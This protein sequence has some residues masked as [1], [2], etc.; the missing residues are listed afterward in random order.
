[1]KTRIKYDRQFQK[2][3]KVLMIATGSVLILFA[4]V[5][6]ATWDDVSSMA[7][8]VVF[9]GLLAYASVPLFPLSLILY[10]DATIYLIRLEKN[11]FSIPEKKKDYDDDLR[12]VPR[13][14]VVENCYAKD[15][16]I[17]MALA[18]AA[19]AVVLICD[20]A[21]L[22]L[23]LGY[24]ES[25]AVAL[26]VILM[27]LHSYFPIQAV[28]FSKQRDVQKYVDEVDVRDFRKARTGLMGAIGLLL[29]AGMIAALSVGMAHTMT[30]YVYKSRNRQYER[31]MDDFH[32]K[33][34][35]QPEVGLLD[36]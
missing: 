11:H 26:F 36:M 19:Y 31:T 7:D 14:E 18:L 20:V 15:S 28:R 35:A 30:K 34:T 10:L 5:L 25:D 32:D 6:I 1:M 22:V 2:V 13:T 33:A 3:C 4:C 27:L 8:L 17:A 23:W 24:G 9:L 12:K 29:L 16:Q 21:Y